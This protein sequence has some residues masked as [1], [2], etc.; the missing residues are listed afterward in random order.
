MPLENIGRLTY[1]QPNKIRKA[2]ALSYRFHYCAFLCRRGFSAAFYKVVHY[3]YG[4]TRQRPHRCFSGLLYL[5][6]LCPACS[7]LAAAAA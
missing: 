2:F 1:A 4:K 6:A 5:P 7:F 3:L